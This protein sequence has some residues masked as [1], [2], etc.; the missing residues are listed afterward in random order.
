MLWGCQSPRKARI[1]SGATHELTACCC[2]RPL[3]SGVFSRSQAVSH[4]EAHKHRFKSRCHPKRA[5]VRSVVGCRAAPDPGVS[6][7][8]GSLTCACCRAAS[9]YPFP[10]LPNLYCPGRKRCKIFSSMKRKWQQKGPFPGPPRCLSQAEGSPQTPVTVLSQ[11]VPG[12]PALGVHPG[13][14]C[15]PCSDAPQG[16]P[17]GGLHFVPR[18]SV[19]AGNP[20]Q[21]TPVCCSPPRRAEA[22]QGRGQRVM[23]MQ[24]SV[25][26]FPH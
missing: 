24:G 26:Q 4:W 19:D 18:P 1:S 7:A 10:P 13:I 15:H 21:G 22:L 9:Q 5:P 3:K 11:D 6:P 25:P 14:H 20:L 8:G 16:S 2:C 23:A 17:D 12:R